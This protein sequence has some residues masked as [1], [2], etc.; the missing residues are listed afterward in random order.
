MEG[1]AVVIRT[2]L[3]IL[4]LFG[5]FPYVP[6]KGNRSKKKRK[7][8][9]TFRE[10]KGEDRED[11]SFV[12]E[13]TGIPKCLKLKK[14]YLVASY[15]V[16]VVHLVFVVESLLLSYGILAADVGEDKTVKIAL[17]LRNLSQVLGYVFILW[18]IRY[19]HRKIRSLL[20]ELHRLVWVCGIVDPWYPLKDK[21]F[22]SK[23]VFLVFSLASSL[24]SSRTLD[25]VFALIATFTQFQNASTFIGISV[26][27]CNIFSILL[28]STVVILFYALSFLVGSIYAS[29]RTQCDFKSEEKLNKKLSTSCGFSASKL[30]DDEAGTT[31][32]TGCAKYLRF[33]FSSCCKSKANSIE[34]SDDAEA[35]EADLSKLDSASQKLTLECVEEKM[36]V[37]NEFHVLMNN[38]LAAPLFAVVVMAAITAVTGIFFLAMDIKEIFLSSMINLAG[39]WNLFMLCLSPE[40]YDKEVSIK[41]SSRVLYCLKIYLKYSISHF[42][43]I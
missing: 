4:L 26:I 40:K 27:F 6:F 3:F 5:C 42:H 21:I 19:N 10:E 18:Y 39:V 15:F 38:T 1:C 20:L 29:L 36:F 37:L 33:K 11:Y 41:S 8:T 25:G 24:S 14:K 23:I 12:E 22:L 16:R 28:A 9:S 2:L 43:T 32:I 17:S 7:Q 13:K 30:E 31:G 34:N 35:P